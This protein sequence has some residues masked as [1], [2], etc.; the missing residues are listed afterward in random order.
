MKRGKTVFMEVWWSK[1]MK[2]SLLLNVNCIVD[3]SVHRF[4]A[5]K[6]NCSEHLAL[7]FK[8]ASKR[9]CI[10]TKMK[11]EN[12]LVWPPCPAKNGART[13]PRDQQ[14]WAMS[15]IHAW[16]YANSKSQVLAT[17]GAGDWWLGAI[18]DEGASLFPFTS[19]LSHPRLSFMYS[20]QYKYSGQR[21]ISSWTG[22]SKSKKC[23]WATISIPIHTPPLKCKKFQITFHFSLCLA[24]TWMSLVRSYETL[25]WYIH[26]SKRK[27]D[28]EN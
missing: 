6:L 15:T 7:W 18:S 16:L 12:D 3:H 9:A 26:L 23:V 1:S 11:R 14:E 13:L 20:G 17:Q 4:S 27:L 22:S 5:N 24:W 21:H 19:H 25:H 8:C 28:S 10:N 2:V